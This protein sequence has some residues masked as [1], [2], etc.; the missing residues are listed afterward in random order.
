MRNLG[1]QKVINDYDINKSRN[2][3]DWKKES[4]D[5]YNKQFIITKKMA[6]D[7][8]DKEVKNHFDHKRAKN[9]K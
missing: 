2:K 4:S 8:D 9:F 6:N 7:F 5:F 3:L 1:R